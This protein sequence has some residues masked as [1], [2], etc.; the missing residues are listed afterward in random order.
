[1]KRKLF[2]LLLVLVL[3]LSLTVPALA[4]STIDGL[5]YDGTD[6][7]DL[8][9]V[10]TIEDSFFDLSEVCHVEFRVDVVSDLEGYEIYDYAEL[11]YNQ[12]EYGYGTDRDG[13]LLM[14]YMTED[15]TG[16]TLHEG[17][18]FCGGVNADDLWGFTDIANA[19]V[20]TYVSEDMWAGPIANDDAM[21]SS[22]MQAYLM[23]CE[24]Y[25]TGEVTTAAGVP[26][27]IAEDADS[28]AQPESAPEAG[29]DNSLGYIVDDAQ[30]LTDSEWEDLEN[31]AAEISDEYDCGIYVVI[32]ED[33][34]DFGTSPEVASDNIYDDYAL[35]Y[36]RQD[37]AIMLLLSMEE[38]DF[39]LDD[40]GEYASEAMTD[41]GRETLEEAMLDDLGDDQWYDGL[42][43]FLDQAEIVLGGYE[44]GETVDTPLSTQ[45][46]KSYGFALIIG[47]VIA[48]GICTVFKNQMK[49]AVKATSASEYVSPFGATILLRQD[50]YTHTTRRER[51]IERDN[52]SGGSNDSG[53]GGKF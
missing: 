2:C 5:I 41:Y 32:V 7:L 27:P 31:K 53:G 29:S 49:T 38:R 37:S 52:D 14:L 12:Y 25:F 33:F 9:A 18:I 17:Q 13:V 48:L 45:L 10:Q 34:N 6:C 4:A 26:S 39:W 46:L 16:V 50:Q 44:S 22:M 3:A 15:S 35:G 30:I 47:L 51:R 23:A 42:D 24:S 21:F 19:Y 43:D 11:F 1:M 40:Y 36:G 28:P 20:G 8:S